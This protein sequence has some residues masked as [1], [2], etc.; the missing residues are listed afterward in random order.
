LHHHQ[1][2]RRPA[3]QTRRLLR[4]RRAAH[5]PEQLHPRRVGHLG[6]LRRGL[7]LGAAEPEIPHPALLDARPLQR[8]RRPAYH[9]RRAGLGRRRPA[10]RAARAASRR[11][12]RRQPRRRDGPGHGAAAPGPRRG[13]RVVRHQRQ[14]P[15]GQP[16]DVGRADRGCGERGRAG[17]L[18]RERRGRAAGGADGAA[19]VRGR[20]LRRRQ[21]GGGDRAGQGHGAEQQPR[22]LQEERR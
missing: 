21:D 1:R 18:G 13:V 16:Q 2:Q 19:V 9:R 7:P 15:D 17:E 10:R 6:R 8:L 20:E 3:L 12:R 22:R 11:R 14:E 5:R 4:P